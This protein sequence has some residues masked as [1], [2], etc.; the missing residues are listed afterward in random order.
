[1]VKS[2]ELLNTKS[3]WAGSKLPGLAV[4]APVGV[5]KVGGGTEGEDKTEGE[6]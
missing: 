3:E 2:E 1:M 5:G 4:K 6:L